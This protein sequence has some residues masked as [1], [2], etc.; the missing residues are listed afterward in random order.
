[1]GVRITD[2]MDS[3]YDDT[4]LLTKTDF[5][6]AE[7]T[8][9]LTMNK[10]NKKHGSKKRFPKGLLI[11]AILVLALSITAGAVGYSVWDAAREDLGITEDLPEYTEFGNTLDAT[12]PVTQETIAAISSETEDTES[13][14]V[15]YQPYDIPDVPLKDHLVEDAD[16]KVISTFCSGGNA[17][18]YFEVSPVT[19]AMAEMTLEEKQ[20]LDVFAYWEPACFTEFE[21]KEGSHYGATMVEYNEVTQSAL[22][23]IDI[24]GDFLKNAEELAFGISWYH[25]NNTDSEIKFYG[26]V[27]FPLTQADSLTASLDIPVTNKFIEQ[28]T[29]T[30]ESV[31]V[32]AG[33]I[34][35]NCSVTPT[36]DLCSA[37]GENAYQIICESYQ[38]HWGST[39]DNT[40]YSDLDTHVYYGRSWDVTMGEMLSEVCLTLD[41][42]TILQIQNG[43]NAW[44]YA[45]TLNIDTGSI[46]ETIELS[47]PVAL[48]QVVG[49]TINDVYYALR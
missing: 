42:G 18:I 46:I 24:F 8:I 14:T 13:N 49:I 33:N 23:R 48:S 20:G 36:N 45:N 37:L 5:P 44:L 47:T 28:A 9:K 19:P 11:A 38:N 17:S 21:S 30:I 6:T 2:L 25:Q 16:I 22:L 40:S 32:W 41:D 27:E 1:M 34:S 7:R 39:D 4:V 31:E 3:Y 10:I 12:D 35:I 26:A 43:I 15:S 29:G